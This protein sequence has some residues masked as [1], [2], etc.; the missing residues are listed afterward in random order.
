[1]KTKHMKAL[2]I[3]IPPQLYGQIEA[4]ATV[5]HR[6]INAEIMMLLE[7]AIDESVGRDLSLARSGRKED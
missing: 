3:R 1:M 7:Q 5:S 4:R 6:T 2:T